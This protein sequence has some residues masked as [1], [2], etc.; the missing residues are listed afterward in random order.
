MDYPIMISQIF[1]PDKGAL[2][3]AKDF[4]VYHEGKHQRKTQIMS[5]PGDDRNNC[6]NNK[7][8]W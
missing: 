8:M 3:V 4:P 7:N 5:N 1:I 6:D 2:Q